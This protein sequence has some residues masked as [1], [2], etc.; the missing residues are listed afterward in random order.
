MLSADSSDRETKPFFHLFAICLPASPLQHL[1]R[2][3]VRHWHCSLANPSPQP[4]PAVLE[5]CRRG[6]LPLRYQLVI[7]FLESALAGGGF[8]APEGRR[9]APISPQLLRKT[10]SIHSKTRV[11]LL[12]FILFDSHRCR[13][14]P[15]PPCA[16]SLSAPQ[17]TWR[18]SWIDCPRQPPMAPH[19]EHSP[20]T[21]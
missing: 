20:S 2:Q 6:F 21:T 18:A 7:R 15:R 16:L 9:C 3:I 13:L 10:R 19:H 17:T 8:K 1:P 11:A 4:Q 14:C 5:Y 12:C